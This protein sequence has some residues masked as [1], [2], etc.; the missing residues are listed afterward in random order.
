MANYSTD[1]TSNCYDMWSPTTG[2]IHTTQDII[3]L[4]QMYFPKVTVGHSTEGDDI[5]ATI[6]VPTFKPQSGRGCTNNS[7]IDVEMMTIQI[8]IQIQIKKMT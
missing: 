3:W 6:N 2:G 5:Q 1:H 8:Q 7:K 4:K